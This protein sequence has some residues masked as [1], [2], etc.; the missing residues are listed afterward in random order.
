MYVPEENLAGESYS[1][2]AEPPALPLFSC[3]SF[4]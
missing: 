4:A 3:Y 2:Q 1:G